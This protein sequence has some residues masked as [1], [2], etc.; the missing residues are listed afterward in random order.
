[1]N[2]PYFLKKP[3]LLKFFLLLIMTVAFPL[4]FLAGQI[5]GYPKALDS[6]EN[7]SLSPQGWQL[8]KEVDNIKVFVRKTSDSKIKEVK[9]TAEAPAGIPEILEV[10]EAV[11]NYPDWVYNCQ[12]AYWL[13]KTDDSAGIYY[14]KIGFPW[15]LR[16]RD[17]I[18]QIRLHTHSDSEMVTMNI[19]GIPK[20]LPEKDNIIRMP[21]MVINWHLTPLA[22]NRTR[23]EYQLRID[24]GGSLPAWMINLAVE[25]GPLK[26][27]QGLLEAL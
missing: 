6:G 26:S 9:T 12:K 23:L 8:R 10:I 16:D 5:P 21:E 1:M 11:R 22:G 3:M 25:E 18:A 7:A 27:M 19:T 20:Y 13:K 2:A 15:P 4:C 17:Y 14:C 24:P